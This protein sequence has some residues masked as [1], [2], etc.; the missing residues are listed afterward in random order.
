MASVD[1]H[2]LAARLTKAVTERT[3]IE[4]LSDDVSDLDLE[5]GYAVQRVLRE[6]ITPAEGLRELLA[7][8]RKAEYPE[9]LFQRR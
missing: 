9:A 2:D 3:A 8:E 1:V 7:R 5:T 4:P 6:Q